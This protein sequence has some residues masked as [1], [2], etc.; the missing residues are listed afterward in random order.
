MRGQ[1]A[2]SYMPRKLRR[3]MRW[4]VRYDAYDVSATLR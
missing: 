2:G 3:V 1:T 4:V